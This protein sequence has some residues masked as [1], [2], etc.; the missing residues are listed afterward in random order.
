MATVTQI[1]NGRWVADAATVWDTGVVPAAGD[2][3]V[4]FGYALTVDEDTNAL[5]SLIMAS[6][7]SLTIDATKIVT[8]TGLVAL[9]Q[10]S[11]GGAGTL[12][13]GG[14][15]TLGINHTFTGNVSIE[16]TG[17]G[18]YID[19]SA[20]PGGANLEINTAGTVTLATDVDCVDFTPTAGTLI[21]TGFELIARGDVLYTL[22]NVTGLGLTMTGTSKNI[23]GI[24]V[25]NRLA[26]LT[27]ATGATIDAIGLVHA[28]KATINGMLNGTGKLVIYAGVAGW[29]GVQT[30]T[31]DCDLTTRATTNDPVNDITLE[32]L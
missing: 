20:S 7:G 23:S 11:S 5:S 1:A 19:G 6:G 18:T 25:G 21:A 24:A 10:A 26:N 29:W 28:E 8:T 3:V 9:S 17:T 14:D 32:P 12:A 2:S 15:L 30:G 22:G 31:L 27:I 16:M 13:C 4:A